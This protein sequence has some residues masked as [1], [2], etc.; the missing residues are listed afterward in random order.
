MPAVIVKF[1]QNA[2]LGVAAFALVDLV[3]D[4]SGQANGERPA[5]R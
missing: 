1:S 2:M 3:D 4:A 5:P